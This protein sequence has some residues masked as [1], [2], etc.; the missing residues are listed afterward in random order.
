MGREGGIVD[1][2]QS[3]DINSESISIIEQRSQVFF[4]FLCITECKIFVHFPPLR[5]TVGLELKKSYF[6][7]SKSET[8]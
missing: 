6:K 4:K 8:A 1:I 5:V 2:Y 7:T 3:V